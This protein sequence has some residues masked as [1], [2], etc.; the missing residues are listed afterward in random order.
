MKCSIIEALQD[1]SVLECFVNLIQGGIV[2][3]LKKTVEDNSAVIQ[4]LKSSLEERNKKIEELE[5]KIDDL[6]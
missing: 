4:S 3:E 1:V 6:E 2:L 5:L